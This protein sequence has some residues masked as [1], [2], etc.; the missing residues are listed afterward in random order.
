MPLKSV[1][2]PEKGDWHKITDLKQQTGLNVL[3]PWYVCK[4]TH[5][6]AQPKKGLPH[7]SW[8]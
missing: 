4:Q 3:M 6:S 2:P 7:K 5:T 1:N 8:R